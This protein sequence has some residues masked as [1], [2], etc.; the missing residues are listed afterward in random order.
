MAVYEIMVSF[1]RWQHRLRK[2]GLKLIHTQC[3]KFRHIV[4]IVKVPEF[5]STATLETACSV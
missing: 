4:Y 3:I 5:Q 2:C 1:N